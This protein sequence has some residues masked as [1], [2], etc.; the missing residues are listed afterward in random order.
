[1]QGRRDALAVERE[2]VAADMLLAGVAPQVGTVHIEHRVTALER[3]VKKLWEVLRPGTRQVIA[4][5]I[6]YGL[7]VGCWS[8]WMIKE[9]RDWFFSHPTQAILIT[10]A[11]IMAALLIRWLPED[12]DHE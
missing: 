11:L 6:F 1:M 5:V 2:Q 12:A 10:L 8:M 3:E 4:R 9:I 7:L